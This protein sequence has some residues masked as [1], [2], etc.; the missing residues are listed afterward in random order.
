MLDPRFIEENAEQIKTNC[1]NRNVTVDIDRLL[2]L[3]ALRRDKQREL[4]DLR[5]RQNETAKAVK[6]AKSREERMPLIEE[7]KELKQQVAALEDEFRHIASDAEDLLGQ[8]PNMAHPDA[9]VGRDESDNREIRVHGEPTSFEFEP[10]DHVE[11]GAL[12]DVIDFESGA[13][14]AG[15]NFYFLKNELVFLELALCQFAMK[16]LHEKG[17]KPHVTPDLA[18][19]RILEGTGF[20]PRGEETQ[21]YSVNDSDL[22]LIATSEITLGGMLSEKI[23][24]ADELPM[25][26]AGLSHCFRTEAGAHGRVSRGLYRVHQ[27]TKVEMFAFARPEDSDALHEE[28]TGIQEEIFQELDV[29]Y[30]VVDTCTGDLGGPAYRKYDLEAWMP[31]RG[32]KGDWGEVTS[33]SNCTDYQARR[34]K[35]RFRREKGARPE[36]LH[37]LNGTAIAVSRA[38]IAIMEN[39]QNID[40]SIDIP[41]VLKPLLA[42]ERIEPRA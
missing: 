7:G 20:I 41:E 14:V 15:N 37:T 29:P 30:R 27:F 38:L 24:D 26:L 22:C 17:Y 13:H 28:M 5:R 16:K 12:C 33:V 34:L 11:L 25:R 21:I 18:R 1:Q 39:Y 9:P 2:E 40:G 4:D 3:I 6:K 23:V 32:E 36:L 8:V 42:F 10:K 35:A 19:A 31:G